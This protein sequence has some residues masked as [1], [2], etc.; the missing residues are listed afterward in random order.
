MTPGRSVLRALKDHTRDLHRDAERHVRILDADATVDDY[1]RYLVAMHGFHA[2]AEDIFARDPALA[3][4]GFTASE[5]RKTPLLIAD[6]AAIT[7]LRPDTLCAS[8]TRQ[9]ARLPTSTSW[10]E[11]LGMAYVVEG[12]T[13]GGKFILAHLPPALAALRGTAT[14]FLDGYG[15]ATAA[16][17]RGFV[18]IVDHAV[19]D[20]ASEDAIV[21][22]ARATFASLIAWLARRAAS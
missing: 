14:A 7:A 18:A 11:R 6:L 8:A 9:C 5:R 12:S 20:A 13:L 1:A 22:G 3:A 10:G 2:P 21:R 4:L 16:R 19:R 15:A 17:W